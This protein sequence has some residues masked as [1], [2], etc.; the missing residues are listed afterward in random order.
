MSRWHYRR[1]LASRVA[2]LTVFAV[3][4]SITFMAVG[5]FLMI[6]NQLQSTLDASLMNRAEK[7][8]KFSN[9]SEALTAR[10]PSFMLGAADV[11]IIGIA[12]GYQTSADSSTAMPSLGAPERAVANGTRDRW[13]RTTHDIYGTPYRV[14]TVN[15][16]EGTALALAQPMTS[17]QRD[18][19]RLNLVMGIVGA[20]GILVSAPAGW[21]VARNGL[22]PVRRLTGS[23][24]RIARTEDL[25]PLAV[26]GDD[27]VARL[28]GAFNQMLQA[29]SASR[30]RQRRMIADASHELRTP[31]TSLR[32]NVELLTQA[33]RRGGLP[34]EARQEILDDVGAQIEELSTLVG[35][36]VELN[37]DEP[38][39]SAVQT[40]DLA[41]VVGNAITRVRRRAPAGVEFDVEL[42]PW[43]VV[44]EEPSLERAVTNLLDNAAKWSPS[45]GTITVTLVDGVLT[46][47]DEGPGIAES[48]LPHVFDRFYRSEESRAMPGSGLGLSIVRQVADRHSG[49]VRAGRSPANGA[50]LQLW[51]PGA[52]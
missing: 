14:A 26:E 15:T 30:D 21:M 40:V 10:Y 3:G 7:A 16:G 33:E 34:P 52:G 24:E 5:S 43:L 46:V 42:R 51:I 1:S 49:A 25:T 38:S 29:L 36:L 27:E 28:G 47:D 50:R 8:A 6:R 37:R 31:L 32:T 22:R 41:E 20:L 17:L 23:V 12:G 19:D 39:A 45:E 48:D 18:L 13:I 2:L 44:G 4:L 9:L 35:D 11:Q